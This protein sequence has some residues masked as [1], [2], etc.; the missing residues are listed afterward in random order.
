MNK[1]EMI[2]SKALVLFANEGY[3]GIGV[4]RI[5]QEVDVTKPTL[6]HYFGNKEGVL[7]SIYEVYFQDVLTIYKKSLPFEQDIMGTVQNLIDRYIQFA[8]QNVDFFWLMNHLRKGPMQSESYNIVKPFHQEEREVLMTLMTEISRFH[9]N[10]KGL[11]NIL[12]INLMSLLNGFVEVMISNN[13]LQQV[14]SNDIHK[15][16]KQFLYGIFSL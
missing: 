9:T 8:K 16:A 1:K 6:Y 3:E 15:L 2:L 12:V 4:Q 14:N 11:E 10:L 5:V 13:E 7:K